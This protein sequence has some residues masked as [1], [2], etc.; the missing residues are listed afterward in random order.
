MVLSLIVFIYGLLI[1]SFINVVIIRLPNDEDI[2]VSRSKCMSCGNTLRYYDLV[3]VFSFLFN[4]GKCRYCDSK[5]SFM[6]MTVELYT[7]ITAVFL[8]NYTPTFIDAI[9]YFSLFCMITIVSFI[10]YKHGVMFDSVFIFFA[11]VAAILMFF[12]HS[13]TIKDH[14][15]G[16][17]VGATF[18]GLVYLLAKLYYKKEAFGQGDVILLG[19]IG[20]YLGWKA[21]V[22]IGF[23]AFYVAAIILIARMVKDKI[24]NKEDNITMKSE[25]YF[26]PSVGVATLLF[27][28][29]NLIYHFI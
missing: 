3:P 20:L 29:V 9:L 7:A 22:I 11:G 24:K 5:I 4:R 26:G 19:V 1:G 16:L 6:Y 21:A 27:C 10:D 13:L 8:Y 14:L 12:N 18:Y 17:I 28:V 23:A 2:F 15:L 25:M